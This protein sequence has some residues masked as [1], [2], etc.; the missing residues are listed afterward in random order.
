M[1]IAF[2]LLIASNILTLL[3]LYTRGKTIRFY[4]WIIRS[5]KKLEMYFLKQMN[6][7]MQRKDKEL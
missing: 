7:M 3:F 2:W 4:Q 6:E 5:D 1:E